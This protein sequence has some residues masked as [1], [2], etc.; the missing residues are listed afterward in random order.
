MD[1]KYKLPLTLIVM[2]LVVLL[3]NSAIPPYA[4][5]KVRE[6]YQLNLQSRDTIELIDAVMLSIVDIQT[7]ARGYAVTHNPVFL[8]PYYRAQERI[9]EQLENLHH[10]VR[11]S[12]VQ[13]RQFDT[14]KGRVTHARAL[15][16]EMVGLQQA[17]GA[18]EARALIASGEGNLRMEA[19]REAV[20]VFRTSET[21]ALNVAR[22]KAEAIVENSN[23]ALIVLTIADYI[24]FTMAFLVLFRALKDSGETH[25][26]LNEL[27]LESMRNGTLLTERNRAKEVQS[28]LVDVLQSV[29]TPEEAYAAIAKFCSQLFPRNPGALFIR[30]HSRD[31]L[32]MKAR[33]GN[34]DVTHGHE[35]SECWAAR[36]NHLYRCDSSE[37]G[38]PCPHVTAIGGIDT[39]VCIP[40]ASSDE[41]IGTLLLVGTSDPEGR[42]LPVET[43]IE[44]Q[45]Q[46]LAKQIGIA[47]AS[48][49]LRTSLRNSSII[50]ALTGL[51]NRRYLDETLVREVARAERL[52]QTVGLILLDVDHFKSF[53]DNFGHEAGDLVLVEV[54]A[55]LKKAARASDMA[56]RYGGEELVIVLPLADLEVTV[57]RAEAIRASIKQIS[58]RY[59]GQHL[60]PITASFGVAVFPLHGADAES[61]LRAAD[62]A[63]YRAKDW[64]RDRVEVFGHEGTPA[65]D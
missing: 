34:I 60:P 18:Q 10:H 42:Q 31:Y 58:V 33:W 26:M 35:P 27:H 24:F 12:P 6:T 65:R 62:T 19:V 28:H 46:E 64:G 54:G 21:Q 50:D 3:L 20:H 22:Q 30:S 1:D 37:H 29:L 4:F 41:M 57:Q 43:E 39:F 15:Y 48:L 61:L 2:A 8:E 14:L 7:G 63:L 56:C 47:L 51:Y 32:E 52:S 55:T 40:V 38:L 23:I 53:N 5:S 59:G 44:S 49:R 17:A 11:E 13:Q 25:R 16:G 36:S 9:D 45:G